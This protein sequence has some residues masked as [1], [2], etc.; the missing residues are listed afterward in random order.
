[1]SRSEA[2]QLLSEHLGLPIEQTH[3]KLFDEATAIKTMY[4]A[5]AYLEKK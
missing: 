1:M 2:Y 4:F 5:R 3:I